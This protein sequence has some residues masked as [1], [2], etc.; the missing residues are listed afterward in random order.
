M[1]LRGERI[2][3]RGQSAHVAVGQTVAQASVQ[4]RAAV[5]GEIVRLQQQPVPAS[6][7]PQQCAGQDQILAQ[8]M[9][10]DMPDIGH[11]TEVR[12]RGTEQGRREFVRCLLG[13]AFLVAETGQHG[14][15]RVERLQRRFAGEHEHPVSGTGQRFAGVLDHPRDAAGL[16]V[17]VDD[18]DTHVE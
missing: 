9:V 8:A 3:Q 2:E 1:D 12:A 15:L 10:M 13:A 14:D 5:L 11:G 17:E 6:G 16:E 4:G 7:Q 18:G